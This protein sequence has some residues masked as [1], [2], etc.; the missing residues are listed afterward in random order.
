MTNAMAFWPWDEERR[1]V[2]FIV[3]NFSGI[4]RGMGDSGGT[5]KK[6]PTV[7]EMNNGNEIWSA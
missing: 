7:H 2:R 5:S 6:Q 4:L 1:F 3:L